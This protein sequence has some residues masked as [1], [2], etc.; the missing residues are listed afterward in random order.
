MRTLTVV[1]TTLLL[2]SAA[3]AGEPW[4]R[5][6]IDSSS[7]G[8]DGVRLADVNGDGR[9][10]IATGWEEGGVIRAYLHPGLQKVRD[11]WP[12]VTVG[13]VAAPEDAVFAD[14]DGDGRPDV[15]SS[16]EGSKRTM[17]VHW[18]PPAGKDYLA[19][20]SWTTAAVPCTAGQQMWM[21]AL[22]FDVDGRHGTDLI[23]GSKNAQAAIGWLQSPANPRDLDAW[24][25]HKLR[26][27]G[28]IMSLEAHDM[29]GD[30]DLDL[31]ASDRKGP[32]RGVFWLE[33]PGAAATV[34][35]EPWPEHPI[36]GADRQVMFL[37]RGKIGK[38]T[39]PAVVCAVSGAGRGLCVFHPRAG[40]K[41][42][43]EE[44]PLPPGCGTGK[45]VGIGDLDGD[46][47]MDLAFT[48]ENATG[49][50]S[51]VRWLEFT[52]DP[53]RP[54]PEHEISGPQGVKFDRLELLDLDGDGDLDLLTC[55]ERDNLGVVWYENPLRTEKR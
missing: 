4:R 1:C 35:G 46:G 51:G 38:A 22:P 9:P 43:L 32:R 27:A 30:G 26:E 18:A 5:H 17:H 40:G 54:W 14:L 13:R 53:K 50:L 44:I 36:G 12:A 45:G 41:W 23:V 52:G 21:Y 31:L 37:A 19:A 24:R 2:L 8:A 10:D 55:E 34:K 48:C 42:E 7:R 49:N 15:V 6:V 25:Y 33:N 29:D 3:H 11:S 20:D 39:T 16:S 47:D 28:W